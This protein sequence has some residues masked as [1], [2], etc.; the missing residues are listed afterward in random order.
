MIDK[1][2]YDILMYKRTYDWKS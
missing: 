2:K 1:A